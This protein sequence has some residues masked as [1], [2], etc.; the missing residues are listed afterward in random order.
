VGRR[1]P[2]PVL[3]DTD[4][5]GDVDDALALAVLLSAPEQVR[6]VAVTTVSG[7]T[8]AR[9]FG[10]GRLL[11]EAGRRD[12]EL[13]AGARDPLVRRNEYPLDMEG[14]GQGPVAAISDEPAPERIVRAA[15]ELA[16]L[17]LLFVGPLTNLARALALD[18]K[19]PSR[20]ARL[21]IM[22]GH[23]R[24]VAIGDH[25]CAPGI[26]Y[27]LCSD[28]EAAMCVLGA[29]FTTRLVTADV[30]LKVWMTEAQRVQLA[31]SPR[32]VPRILARLIANW[33]P[34]QI[35]IFTGMG[36]TLAPDNAA[37]LHDPLTALALIDPA[38]LA[39][40]R[41]H[42]LPTIQRGV[43]RTIE[44]PAALG[45]GTEMECALGVDAPRA[46]D[47]IVRRVAGV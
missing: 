2:T 21:T 17:E 34:R 37:F 13:C 30:T 26:D 25:V 31:A 44:V 5:S 39:F 20:V 8:R 28:P 36:G 10:A 23:I 22:G 7:D 6:L 46:R 42:V 1:V 12:V 14:Y 27:N 35:A 19:L 18:P 16:G 41:I 9:A 29:G 3:F 11:A 45:L 24:R 40:E 32:P 4:I 38:P 33:T 43:L 15:R 47:E